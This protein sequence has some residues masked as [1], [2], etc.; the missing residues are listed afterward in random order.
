MGK[1]KNTATFNDFAS[2]FSNLGFEEV[3]KSVEENKKKAEEE[4]RLEQRRAHNREIYAS[5]LESINNA[6]EALFYLGDY[7]GEEVK[8][9]RDI[10]EHALNDYQSVG[11][12]MY[13]L[14]LKVLSQVKYHIITEEELHELIKRVQQ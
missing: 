11:K 14:R 2:A 13:R 9:M 1:K 8:V 12:W 7:I 4:K 6:I 3:V 5:E 10:N